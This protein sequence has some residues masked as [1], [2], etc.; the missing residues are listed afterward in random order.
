M[1]KSTK[2]STINKRIIAT[3]IVVGLAA[4]AFGVWRYRAGMVGSRPLVIAVKHT[5]DQQHAT[6]SSWAEKV[7]AACDCEIEWHDVT[8]D[9]AEG[10][11]AYEMSSYEPANDMLAGISKPDIFVNFDSISDRYST[12]VKFSGKGT[13]DYLN[14]RDY[15]DD[16]PNV[17]S[18]FREV[19]KAFQAA[20][21]L[22]GRILS[23]PGDAGTDY[24]GTLAHMFINRSWLEKL[25]LQIP[26]TWEELTA[27]LR[28]FRDDDPNESGDS[29]EIPFDIRPPYDSERRDQGAYEDYRPDGWMLM[30]NSVGIPTQLQTPAGRGGFY[31]DSGAIKN[32]SDSDEFHTVSDYLVDL[33]NDGLIPRESFQGSYAR[34]RNND[35]AAENAQHGD[36]SDT[37]AYRRLNLNVAYSP[38]QAMAD[39]PKYGIGDKEYQAQLKSDP[40]VVGV[41]F[42][43]DASA[44]GIH[45]DEYESIPIPTRT[46]DTKAT[47]GYNG[48][49]RFNF[50]G[51][52]IR[53]NTKHR[54]Q[55]LKAVDALFDPLVSLE[56]YYGEHNVKIIRKDDHYQVSITGETNG[57]GRSFIG[58]VEPGTVIEGDAARDL[59]KQAEKP[60]ANIDQDMSQNHVFPMSMFGDLELGTRS[61]QQETSMNE[62]LSERIFLGGAAD[63]DAAW[64]DYITAL[65]NSQ[66]DLKQWQNYYDQIQ[67]LDKALP[68]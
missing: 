47:W 17:S 55:A 39:H 66:S 27:V 38:V 18:Y 29:D 60:Y 65:G 14:L 24:D 43:K 15:L 46:A 63:P 67:S 44:F 59:Y 32:F 28:A 45:A 20:Q 61:A 50:T 34:K 49:A 22:D 2:H 16:M 56:Q 31:M 10:K 40:A 5:S 12:S 11:Y 33:A 58:W 19:P 51:V 42:A 68:K 6:D 57:Y 35:Q 37:V 48:L 53:S 13:E 30:M 64:T 52:S 1:A 25:N 23:I 21:E 3:V 36:L 26:A 7:V 62:Y 4:I 9:S 8:P 41:A 54:D